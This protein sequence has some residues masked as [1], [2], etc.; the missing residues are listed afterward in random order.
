MKIGVILK[1]DKYIEKKIKYRLKRKT[2]LNLK[3]QN[4]DRMC[5]WPGTKSLYCEHKQ[6]SGYYN[7]FQLQ[8][9]NGQYIHYIFD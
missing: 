7:C 4:K 5:V 3:K 6:M 1:G 2:V 9:I 8:G